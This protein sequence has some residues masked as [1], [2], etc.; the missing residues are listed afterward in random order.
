MP[1]QYAAAIVG[2][3]PTEINASY[4][5]ATPYEKRKHY[6][7]K[8]ARAV[9]RS[10]FYAAFFIIVKKTVFGF[11]VFKLCRFCDKITHVV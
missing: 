6:K 2:A 11:K 9:L 10:M 4:L 7:P 1:V 3:T 5:T 8:E